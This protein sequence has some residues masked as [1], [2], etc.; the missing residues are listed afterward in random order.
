MRP[1]KANRLLYVY[2]VEWWAGTQHGI[3]IFD[4]K[5]EQYE[6]V[7][8]LRKN[9]CHYGAWE[10]TEPHEKGFRRGRGGVK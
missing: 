7:L 4:N 1:T 2:A 9:K 3:A 10:M 5:Q 8:S 6:L